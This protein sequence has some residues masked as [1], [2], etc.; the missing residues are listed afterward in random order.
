MQGPSVCHAMEQFWYGVLRAP[1]SNWGRRRDS[2][3]SSKPASMGQA[4]GG[5][6]GRPP[7]KESHIEGLKKGGERVRGQDEGPVGGIRS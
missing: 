7:C 5:G 6:E 1:R 4:G 3:E 2:P